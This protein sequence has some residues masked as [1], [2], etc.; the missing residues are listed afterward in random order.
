MSSSLDGTSIKKLAALR[1]VSKDIFAASVRHASSSFG[2]TISDRAA[3]EEDS[4]ASQHSDPAAFKE[5][6]GVAATLFALVTQNGA[7]EDGVRLA[8]EEAGLDDDRV[9]FCCSQYTKRSGGVTKALSSSALSIPRIVSID[10]RLDYHVHSSSTGRAN[11]PMY[12]VSLETMDADGKEG[13]SEFR[14]SL[15]QLQDLASKVQDAHKQ[16]SRVQKVL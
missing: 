7:G 8:L 10:W 9:K 2:R 13:R 4:K 14:C 6:V 16:V 15:Q 3:S 1:R 12:Y 5:C 11:V